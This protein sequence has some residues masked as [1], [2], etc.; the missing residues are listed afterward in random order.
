METATVRLSYRLLLRK[1]RGYFLI[2]F[3][4]SF[5]AGIVGAVSAGSRHSHHVA[6]SRNESPLFPLLGLVWALATLVILFLL[7]RRIG[8]YARP[9]ELGTIGLD[10][11]MTPLRRPAVRFRRFT[12]TNWQWMRWIGLGSF[13]A[14]PVILALNAQ[15]ER[16][17]ALTPFL[18]PQTDIDR[19]VAASGLPVEGDWSDEV[20]RFSLR[21]R[22]PGSIDTRRQA[23]M[24]AGL[25]LLVMVLLL[26]PE[27]PLVLLGH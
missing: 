27:I 6:T 1:A 18:H 19:L 7:L 8:Y 10:G 22:W 14:I 24:A 21:K 12:M 23:W 25:S 26:I 16:A 4:C 2:L 11:R 17:L 20:R 15:G 9:G 13:R 5:F 3:C